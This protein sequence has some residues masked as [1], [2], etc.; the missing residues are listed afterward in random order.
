NAVDSNAGGQY[1]YVQSTKKGELIPAADRK[2]AGAMK[3][4]LMDG[5]Q[6]QLSSDVGQVVVLNYF[7]SWCPPCQTETPQFDTVYRARKGQGVTFVGVDAKDSPKSGAASW[8]KVKDI[9]FPVLYDPSAQT[10]LELGGVPIV[11]LPATVLIDKQGKVAAVYQ[12]SL[13]PADLNPLL[14]QLV[15]ET[16]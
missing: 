4:T 6:Y 5:A 3:G 13:L 15:K 7:A 1:R 11:T 9:T 10:A 2:P 16:A 14:N 12:S 8:L